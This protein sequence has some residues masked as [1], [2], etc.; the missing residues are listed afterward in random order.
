MQREVLD[1]AKRMVRDA[2]IQ[3]L[4]IK[5]MLSS[6]NTIR[7]A[8]FGCSV[9]PNTFIAMQHV[10][11]ALK[12]KLLQV[13]NSTNNIPEFQIFFNDHVINDFNTLFQSLPIDRSYYAFG[14]PR[15][16]HGR[17]FPSR[18]IHFAH[19][20][21][22]IHWLSKIYK[23]L[24][25]EKSPAWN[26]GSIHYICTSNVEVVNSYVAQFEKDMEM[27]LNARAEEIVEGGMMVLVTPFA[28]YTRLM[29]FFGSSLMDLVNEGKLD[30]SL[31]DSFNFPMYFPSPEDMTKVVEKN[32]CFSIEIMELTYAK[33]KLVEKVDAKTLMINLRAVLEGLIINHFGSEIAKEACARIILKSEEISTWMKAN[34][35]KSCQLFVALKHK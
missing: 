13:T 25:D 18:S 14:V 9:G 1:G 17:L 2:I 6:S 4:D 24:L 22:A 35:E 8:D 29:N 16:F 32:G 20:S 12:D 30:E 7:I 34:Y 33:S 27:L 15:T 31:V 23:E 5:I 3:K 19:S 21:C 11:Q 26:K 28:S 10:V